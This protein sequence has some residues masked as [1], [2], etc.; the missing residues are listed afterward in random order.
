MQPETRIDAACIICDEPLDPS[1]QDQVATG[2]C[3]DCL[4]R[5]Y[6]CGQ[7]CDDDPCEGARQAA[8]DQAEYERLRAAQPPTRCYGRWHWR[9]WRLTRWVFSRLYVWGI[10][11]TGGCTGNKCEG[12]GSLRRDCP[13]HPGWGWIAR[14]PGWRSLLGRRVYVLGVRTDW[15]RMLPRCLRAGHWPLEVMGFCGKCAPWPCC[16]ATGYDHA[17]WCQG[18]A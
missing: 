13:G 18:D 5:C 4:S 11:A 8:I 15:L 6:W 10:T 16:G 14:G 12:L 7:H 2:M 1:E 3:G 9:R 17:A